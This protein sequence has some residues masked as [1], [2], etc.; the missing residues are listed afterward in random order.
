MKRENH[1]RCS[2]PPFCTRD[3][4]FRPPLPV[5]AERDVISWRRDR[6]QVT[7]CLLVVEGGGIVL[8]HSFERDTGL[9]LSFLV[10][11]VRCAAKHAQMFVSL[12]N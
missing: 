10:C 2:S 1:V 9:P 6:C 11:V 4:D 3:R 5:S 12:K 8:E 7:S